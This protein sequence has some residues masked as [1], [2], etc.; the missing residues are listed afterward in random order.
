VDTARV[1]DRGLAALPRPMRALPTPQTGG[2]DVVANDSDDTDH[3]LGSR[4][5]ATACRSLRRRH[6]SDTLTP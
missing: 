2:P 1:C 3:L 4:E 6:A 5:L